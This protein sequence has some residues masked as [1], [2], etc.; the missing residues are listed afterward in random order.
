MRYRHDDGI[1]LPLSLWNLTSNSEDHLVIGGCDCVKLADEY[2]TPLHVVDMDRL[3]ANYVLFEDTFRKYY[4]QTQIHCSYK[5]NPVPGVLQQLH[6]LGANAEVISHFELWLAL[7]LK[8]GPER[9]IFNGPGKTRESLEMAVSRGV[10][11]IN[12]D[13][14]REGETINEI[15]QKLARVQKVGLRI[16]TSVGW[17]AQ[18]GFSIQNGAAFDFLRE[19][20]KFDNIRPCGLHLHLGTG[21]KDVSAYLKA[22]REVL[23]FSIL[24]RKNLGIQIQY[25][26]LGGGFGVPTVKHFDS[27]D[28]SLELHGR[29][30]RV[31]D[32]ES[33]PS[34]DEY[35]RRTMMLVSHYYPRSTE[36]P[37]V[38]L[39]PGRALMSS[40]QILLARVLELKPTGPKPTPVIIDAGKNLCIPTSWEYHELIAAMSVTGEKT[41]NYRIYGPLCHPNDIVFGARRL[42]TLKRDQLL[43][44][45]DS[46][47]YF[48]PN[49]RI[50]S[51]PRP[52]IIAVENGKHRIMRHRENFSDIVRLDEINSEAIDQHLTPAHTDPA[53]G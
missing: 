33:F 1:S 7:Q 25:L 2:G 48:I 6:K 9:I 17:G 50:F 19:L 51:F 36:A 5:T 4:P 52:S 37:I 34:I 29:A 32:P 10:S 28:A 11:L 38:I 47:A 41:Q 44:I 14:P 13:G 20:K 45:M 31:P 8:V 42:P 24:L 15:A 23:D 46:G 39:E 30:P 3:K 49:Q 21:I 26:D 16:V 43:A 18:F 53:I 22:I 12:I 27:T 35:A 40:S